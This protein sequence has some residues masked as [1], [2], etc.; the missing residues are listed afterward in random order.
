M[1]WW[2]VFQT[3][4]IMYLQNSRKILVEEENET[5]DTFVYCTVRTDDGLRLN[6]YSDY[7]VDA[8]LKNPGY[9]GTQSFFSLNLG[10]FIK[11]LLQAI[12]VPKVY[13]LT[14]NFGYLNQIWL[15]QSNRVQSFQPIILIYKR[16]IFVYR[17]DIQQIILHPLIP[18]NPWFSCYKLIYKPFFPFKIAIKHKKS[19]RTNYRHLSL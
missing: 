13:S 8:Q 18:Y 11:S 1:L 10:T 19:W 6:S 14:L 9:T 3:T 4:I 17:H 7:R 12:L 2:S 15:F 16:S 5:V